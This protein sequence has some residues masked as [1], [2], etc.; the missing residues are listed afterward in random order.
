MTTLNQIANF[1][2]L[3]GKN[4]QSVTPITLPNGKQGYHITYIEGEQAKIPGNAARNAGRI[5][6][7]T[8]KATGKAALWTGKTVLGALWSLVPGR[9]NLATAWKTWIPN[10]LWIS[11]VIYITWQIATRI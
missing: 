5:A 4:V 3:K 9:K 1:P 11:A 7:K 10:A 2:T 6:G 8:A